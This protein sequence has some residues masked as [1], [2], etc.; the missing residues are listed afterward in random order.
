MKKYLSVILCVILCLRALAGCA[1]KTDATTAPED[2]GAANQS[3]GAV[4]TEAA[5]TQ[6]AQLGESPD[7]NYRVWYEIFVYSF[8][9]SDGDGIG[10][11]NGVRSKI[12]Y[13]QEL[14]V[15]GIWFMPLHPS[16]TYHKYNVSDYYAI[17]PQYGTM[18]DF[19]ALLADCEKAGIKVI[20]DLVVNH[21]GSEHVWFRTATEYL[22]NLSEGAEP[23]PEDCKY[24]DYYFFS[25]ESTGVSAPKEVTGT[26]YWY[27]AMFSYDMP[28]LNLDNPAVRAEVEDVMAFWMEKGVAGFRLDAAKEFFT[29][30]TTKNVE[31]L[32]WLQKAATDIDPN[33]YMV[34]E[35]W[36]TFANITNYYESGITSIFNYAFGNV[37][38]KITKVI[39]GAGNSSM[40][41]TYATGLEKAD[42]AYLDKNP[43]YIDAPFLSNHDVGRIAGFAGREEYKVK[44]AGA[45]NIFMGGSVF[46]YYGEE[47]GMAGSGNDPSKRVGM[48]WNDS[49]E[50]MT[51]LP[52]DATE[53]A[54]PFGSLE[55]QRDD[56]G[57]IYNYYRQAVAIRKALPV[58]SHGRVTAE[59]N[60]NKGCVSAQRKTWGSE[61]CIILMNIDANAAQVDLSGYEDW[62][63]AATLSADG[64]EI[65]QNGTALALPAYG[66]AVLIPAR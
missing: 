2:S 23:N 47:L 44:L 49:G 16:T 32:S 60:L 5:L 51:K 55:D 24:L 27:E 19:D 3:K 43:N 9:D 4:K 61:E 52:P 50:G 45:M 31:V 6:I 56:D 66:V 7:D 64:G 10:D 28:D 40:V 48:Y 38:G 8:C 17:D 63:L 1:G 46:I 59:A 41:T 62:S 58:I 25:K 35:V 30:N 54:H 34:A 53:Q 11:L 20:M 13:L 18:E 14:G 29:G 57:S 15:T 65:K 36:D 21:T 22:K 37:D 26:D 33:A 42:K 12:P 39:R